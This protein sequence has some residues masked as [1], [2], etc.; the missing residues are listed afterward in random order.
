M[1]QTEKSRMMCRFPYSR[2]LTEEEQGDYKILPIL[3]HDRCSIKKKRMNTQVWRK[4]SEFS[5][6]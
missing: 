1:Q 2:L 3:A 5:L 4:T 6:A